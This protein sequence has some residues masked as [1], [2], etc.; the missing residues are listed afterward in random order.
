[1]P[2]PMTPRNPPSTA[3][4]DKPLPVYGWRSDRNRVA[5]VLWQNQVFAQVLPEPAAAGLTEE[6]RDRVF[7]AWLQGISQEG[8]RGL[9]DERRRWGRESAFRMRAPIKDSTPSVRFGIGLDYALEQ[10]NEENGWA[11]RTDRPTAFYVLHPDD[12]LGEP[13]RVEQ[14]TPTRLSPPQERLTLSQKPSTWRAVL[15]S[16]QAVSEEIT[17]RLCPPPVDAP[18]AGVD[19]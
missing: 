15:L 12:P 9:S 13:V 4:D 18:S 10:W 14:A 8:P 7:V 19:F 16:R 2:R 1:M 5:M 11:S 17:E 3:D 6:D